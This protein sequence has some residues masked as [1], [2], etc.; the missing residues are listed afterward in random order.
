[1]ECKLQRVLGISAGMAANIACASGLAS[2][3]E[4]VSGLPD[5]STESDP[6]SETATDAGP[7]SDTDMSDSEEPAQEADVQLLLQLPAGFSLYVW[8]TRRNKHHKR[9]LYVTVKG[10]CKRCNA[11][12]ILNRPAML[13]AF[14]KKHGSCRYAVTQP[15]Y[16]C[17]DLHPSSPRWPVSSTL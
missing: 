2:S 16:F 13:R 9:Y 6:H 1:M 17:A 12:P 10:Q 14:L 15:T 3:P 7:D 4:A 5:Q 11:N 8:R